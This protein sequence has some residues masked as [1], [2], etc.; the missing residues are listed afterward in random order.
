MAEMITAQVQQDIEDIGKAVNTDAII[1]PR[2]GEPFESIPMVSRK[3]LPRIT[4]LEQEKANKVE[5][6]DALSEKVNTDEVYLKS[7][8]YSTDEVD[9]VVQA[10][11][12]NLQTQIA[13]VGVGNKA[14]KTYALMDADKTNI[15][16]KSKV[17]VTN[18]ETASNNGDW[19]WD[20]AAF[21]KSSYDPLTQAKQYSESYT[22]SK[23]KVLESVKNDNVENHFYLAD[24]EGDVIGLI[25]QDLIFNFFGSDIILNNKKIS[26][27]NIGESSAEV[28]KTIKK[29]ALSSIFHVVD[30]EEN[31]LLT[32]DQNAQI[33][34]SDLDYSVQ[35][36]LKRISKRQKFSERLAINDWFY[37]ISIEAKEK[38]KSL[39]A[40]YQ[41]PNLKP[42]FT[43][44]RIENYGEN[45]MGTRRIP[46]LC[47]VSEGR[48]IMFFNR[49]RYGYD[50]DGAGADLYK[51][52]IDYDAKGN[53]SV[54]N[55]ELFKSVS[56]INPLGIVK[57]PHLG[58]TS[59]GRL[60]LMF[61]ISTAS[62]VAYSQYQCFSS[63][64]G[65]TWTEPT[66]VDFGLGRSI[67]LGTGGKIITLPSGRL[68]NTFYYRESPYAIGCI[69]SD[70]NGATWE[71]GQ[72]INGTT[73][74]HSYSESTPIVNSKGELLLYCRSSPYTVGRAS[75]FKS[76][77]NG[78]TLAYVG[79]STFTIPACQLSLE[80]IPDRNLLVASHPTHAQDRVQFKISFSLDD[81]ENWDI[82]QV[83]PY[84]DDMYGGYSSTIYLGND[85][86]M[87][88]VEGLYKPYVMNSRE[89][90]EV[91]TMNLKGVMH[92]V[93]S[94]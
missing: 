27:K 76:T 10:S 83:Q 49:A 85:L 67:T 28:Q 82:V 89:N 53:I 38:L 14:Y 22:N 66:L 55:A 61:D 52:F 47:K 74:D 39:L 70:N 51:V 69:Y 77:D 33:H 57:H 54:G 60:I 87:C 88:A 34:I 90:I 65:I 9:Q 32:I 21:T 37:E 40:I 8:T 42:V 7:Q 6:A 80:Q 81:G 58:K 44:K 15:P 20:G 62:V 4:N 45:G 18:D 41:N 92:N 84:D 56:S 91:I 29:E 79:D 93:T 68:L 16:A 11:E 19:Q 75:V 94:A 73:W 1:T 46:V 17:T 5:V 50:G 31:I 63:D 12:L 78:E 48:V 2:V 64:G 3:A 23:T 35:E 36:E 24:S 72:S 26:L 25:D 30:D 71:A 13:A 43:K 86:L 59:D